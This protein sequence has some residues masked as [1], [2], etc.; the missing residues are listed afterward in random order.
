MRAHR[1]EEG[2]LGSQPDQED[3]YFQSLKEIRTGYFVEYMPPRPH[4][5]YA[6]LQ[7]VI[8]RDSI[9][10]KKVCEIMEAELA[11][12]LR[13]YRVPV[14]VSAFDNAGELVNLE[15]IQGCNFLI[16][17]QDESENKVREWRVIKNEEL[18][19]YA[20]NEAYLKKVYLDIP[21]KTD[22][23]LQSSMKQQGTNVQRGLWIIIFWVSVIPAAFAITAWRSEK[24]APSLPL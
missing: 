15:S 20:L 24:R 13:R 5:Q 12:W 1:V 19:K 9:E 7:V 2:L 16:G 17:Y 21:H 6:T 3:I 14:M 18:P 11:I 23:Q 10:E 4:F 8:T 22:S